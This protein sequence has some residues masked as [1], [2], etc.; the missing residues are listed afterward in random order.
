MY[1]CSMTSLLHTPNILATRRNHA[2][3]HAVV[4]LLSRQHT[5]KALVGHSNPRGFL[6]LGEVETT[7]VQAAADEAL[8]RLRSGQKHLAIHPGCGTNLVLNA[9]ALGLGAW[10]GMGRTRSDRER[11]DRI[12]FTGLLAA[13]LLA[14]VQPLGPW[15]QE[16]LTTEADPGPL[17][18]V[19]IRLLRAASPRIHFVET[20]AL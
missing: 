12:P 8:S 3:E 13:A 5:G 14:L 7:E 6:L 20:R 19:S 18:I 11:L 10:I 2:L 4:H 15:V 9:L 16:H 1:N 17:Q